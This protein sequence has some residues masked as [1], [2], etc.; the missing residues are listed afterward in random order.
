MFIYSRDEMEH[1]GGNPTVLLEPPTRELT[2]NLDTHSLRKATPYNTK[3][4]IFLDANEGER[5]RYF[6]FQMV[7]IQSPEGKHFHC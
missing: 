3:Y 1:R 2:W 5:D 4:L 7:D 6:F